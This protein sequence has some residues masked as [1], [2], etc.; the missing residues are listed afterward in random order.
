M[1]P[2]E[3]LRPAREPSLQ[4]NGN[5]GT[6]LVYCRQIESGTSSAPVRPPFAFPTFL[7]IQLPVLRR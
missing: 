5:A 7:A 2:F 3:G 6:S 1:L 4:S